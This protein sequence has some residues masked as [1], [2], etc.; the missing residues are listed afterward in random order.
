MIE[1]IE[2]RLLFR[3]M[4]INIYSFFFQDKKIKK[5]FFQFKIE[6]SNNN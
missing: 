5:A 6:K 1:K 4:I 2:E 3:I